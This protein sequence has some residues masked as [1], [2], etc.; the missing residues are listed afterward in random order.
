MSN[1]SFAALKKNRSNQLS[2]LGKEIEKINNPQQ[3][4]MVMMT[5]SGVQNWISPVM[6][7]PLFGFSQPPKVKNF[8]GFVFSTTAFKGRVVGTSKTL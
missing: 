2:S 8:R 5:V 3:H 7:T 6:V 1:K 4:E